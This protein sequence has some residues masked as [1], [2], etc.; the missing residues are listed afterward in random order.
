MYAK[1]LYL[2]FQLFTPPA[3]A[4]M[5]F[6]VRPMAMHSVALIHRSKLDATS[7]VLMVTN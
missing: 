7:H 4:A 6:Q 2:I 3:T 5:L 1:Q